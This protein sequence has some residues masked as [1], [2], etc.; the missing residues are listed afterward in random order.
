MKAAVPALWETVFAEN[1]KRL[2][3]HR[4]TCILSADAI[5]V[6]S[7]LELRNGL[8]S[9]FH[10]RPVRRRPHACNAGRLTPQRSR[11]NFVAQDRVGFDLEG[12][13]KGRTK[14]QFPAQQHG[15]ANTLPSRDSFSMP[16]CSLQ[17]GEC[18]VGAFLSGVSLGNIPICYLFLGQDVVS[19]G[20]ANLPRPAHLFSTT[21]SYS[22][23]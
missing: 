11:P 6:G 7:S 12:R 5:F 15:S 1:L 3:V 9:L 23:L 18:K 2:H 21:D 22:R 20:P 8:W 13:N 19:G 16:T 17:D 4:S 14:C 10:A